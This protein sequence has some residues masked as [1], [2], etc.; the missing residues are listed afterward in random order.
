MSVGAWEYKP[1]P[2]EA[3]LRTDGHWSVQDLVAL[4]PMNE[5]QGAMVYDLSGNGNHGTCVGGPTRV[6]SEMGAALDFDFN[7]DYIDCSGMS[8]L[9]PTGTIVALAYL[10]AGCHETLNTIFSDYEAGSGT[11]YLVLGAG[12]APSGAND[13]VRTA[14]GDSGFVDDTVALLVGYWHQYAWSWANGSCQV[15]VDGRFI[16]T[17]N[18]TP[19]SFA[20]CDGFPRIGIYGNTNVSPWKG[21]IASVMA[22]KRGLSASEVGWLYAFPNIVY[23]PGGMPWLGSAEAAGVTVTPSVAAITASMPGEL[24][25]GGAL[26]AA[27][28]AD[29]LSEAIAAQALG[30]AQIAASVA[31][32]TGSLPA[33]A[34]TGGAKIAPSVLSLLAE[35]PTE[36]IITGAV[37]AVDRATAAI[38]VLAVILRTGEVVP[39]LHLTNLQRQSVHVV[40]LRRQ[41]V[42][43]GDLRRESIHADL[44]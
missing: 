15:Y 41:Q 36:T 16:D 19:A 10:G 27:S 14:I 44:D 6:S 32:M 12:W 25:T 13:H 21:P 43:V 35:L 7:D 1:P 5:E 33:G 26:I 29:V 17:V 18:Y 23:E 31:D 38:S 22:Y 20:T 30:G 2:G 8:C 39:P 4:Y 24:A 37:V 40:D 9:A 34:V 11:N 3:V 42:H 28:V